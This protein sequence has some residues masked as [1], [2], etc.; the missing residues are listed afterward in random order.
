MSKHFFESKF[1]PVKLNDINLGDNNILADWER[2]LKPNPLQIIRINGLLLKDIVAQGHYQFTNLED[3]KVFFKEVILA[4]ATFD[5]A[6]KDSIINDHLIKSFHQG[7]YLNFLSAAMTIFVASEIPLVNLGTNSNL[8]REID[9]TSTKDGFKTQ[10]LFISKRMHINIDDPSNPEHLKFLGDQGV[11]ESLKKLVGSE[12]ALEFAAD[13]EKYIIKGSA[14]IAVNF[15]QNPQKPDIIIENNYISYGIPELKK[16][17]DTRNPL[18]ILIDF[19]RNILG[20]NAVTITERD[21]DQK[22]N[23]PQ[24]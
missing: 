7:G 17:L 4:K 5:E 10:E 23:S 2:G 12:G 11:P 3:L 20:L 14:T 13:S 21:A 1:S 16:I 22:P 18:E 6:Y 15:L 19:F 24:V 9:I 8:H